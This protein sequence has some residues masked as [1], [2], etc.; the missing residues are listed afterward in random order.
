[1]KCHLQETEKPKDSHLFSIS[2]DQTKYLSPVPLFHR[3]H[4][5]SLSSNN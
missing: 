2:Y 5:A 1:M 4:S 3:H